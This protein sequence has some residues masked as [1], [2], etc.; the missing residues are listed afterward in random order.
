MA[1]EGNVRDFSISDIFQLI[2]LQRKTGVLT[3]RNKDDTVTITFLDGRVVNADSEKYRLES[4]LGKVLLKRG[5]ITEEKLGQALKIQKETL[6]RLGYVMVK[7]GL[8]S[9]EEL[10]KALTQQILEIVYRI[11][12][13]REGEYHFSQE[14]SVEYDRESIIPITS[15]SILM[16]GAQMLDEW[17][18]IERQVKSSAQVFEKT[19]HRQAVQVSEDEEFDFEEG[20]GAPRPHGDEAIKLSQM[21]HDV[22]H[23]VDGQSSLAEIVERSR[24]NEFQVSKALYELVTRGLAQEKREET[25]RPAAA[26]AA[27]E[28]APPPVPMKSAWLPLA[29]ILLVFLGANVFRFKNPANAITSLLTKRNLVDTLQYTSS[30]LSVRRVD[31]AIQTH[32]LTLGVYPANLQGLVSQGFVAEKELTD[33]WGHSYLY[34][35]QEKN[36]YLIG[37][38]K[39]GSQQLELIFTYM[40]SEGM[41]KKSDE[42]GKARKPVV[43]ME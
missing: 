13:W 21:V 29:F 10:K 17:P 20:K 5:S 41:G 15:E 37:F 32:Y 33:P 28:I 36:Y 35:K 3:L 16:E 39:D 9:N 43:I 38:N 23:L 31:E 22:Y 11:F 26:P 7:N 34:Y 25:E 6:Q 8:I 27:V 42:G 1:L 19:S 14:T 30:F 2:G 40:L 4:R 12:R 24:Y 18:I